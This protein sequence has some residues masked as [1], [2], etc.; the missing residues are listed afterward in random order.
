MGIHLS[1][2]FY[3]LHELKLSMFWFYSGFTPLVQLANHFGWCMEKAFFSV[4]GMNYAV[5][6]VPPMALRFFYTN[7]LITKQVLSITFYLP[8][9]FKHSGH[10]GKGKGTGPRTS[11][12]T[13]SL[14]Q[15]GSFGSEPWSC[16][17]LHPLWTRS[18]GWRES[19]PAPVLHKSE[20]ATAQLLPAWDLKIWPMWFVCICLLIVWLTVI[21]WEGWC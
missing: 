6:C 11:L 1:N 17:V 21:F 16:A 13:M 19:L 4:S 18:A 8:V 20:Q 9:E 2:S 14:V 5:L 3:I 12:L 7:T 10:N 15:T